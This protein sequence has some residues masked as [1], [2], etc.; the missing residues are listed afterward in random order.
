MDAIEKLWDQIDAWLAIHASE[1]AN[2]LE[3][4]ATEEEI[5]QGGEKMGMGTFLKP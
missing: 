4:E 2:A 3:D 5:K 1:I